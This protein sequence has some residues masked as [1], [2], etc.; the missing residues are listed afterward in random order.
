MRNGIFIP[1]TVVRIAA[2]VVAAAVVALVVAEA[3][4]AWRYIKMETM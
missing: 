3:P 2:G 1:A 4:E